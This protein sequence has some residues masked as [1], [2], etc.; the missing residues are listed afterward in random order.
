MEKNYETRHIYFTI[1]IMI[2]ILSPIFYFFVPQTV[3]DVV[4]YKEDTW[5]VSTPKENFT[6]FAVA[7]GFLFIASILLFFL[8][9]RKLSIT[10]SVIFLC[11][12]LFTFYIASQSFVS[13]SNEEIS[14]SSLFE[15]KKHTYQ[16]EDIQRVIHY[17][18]ETGSF[19]EFELIFTDGN[20]ARLDDNAYFREK[21]DK[22]GM[23]LAEY[24]LFPE[25]SLVE[26][27]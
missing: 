17:R 25:L 8:N 11:L 15:L 1:A 23:K 21:S 9:I 3:G 22:F 13:L 4:H 12:G 24:N 10:L 7:C 14:Y 26:E 19:S 5:Y 6:S 27:P 16:W 20:R 18:N 2:A